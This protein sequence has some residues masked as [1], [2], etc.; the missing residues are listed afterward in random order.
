MVYLCNAEQREGGGGGGGEWV[1]EW[2][3]GCMHGLYMISGS[4]KNI[5]MV[6]WN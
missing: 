6:S 3:G 4:L 2:V 1:V 5:C